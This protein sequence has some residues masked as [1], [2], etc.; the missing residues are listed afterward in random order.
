MKSPSLVY[1]VTL[2]VLGVAGYAL[3]GAASVTA[4]IPAFFGG[5]SSSQMDQ[6]LLY[7]MS[8]TSILI[9]VS[10]AL[11]MVEKLN[12]MLVMRNY[13]GFMAEQGAGGSKAGGAPGGGRAAARPR[14]R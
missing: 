7:F 1:A 9:V 14:R 11:D 13:E 3:T 12:A 8:G 2:I 6:V 4:L 10:V 5:G